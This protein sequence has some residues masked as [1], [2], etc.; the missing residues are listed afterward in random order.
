MTVLV[1]AGLVL[2]MA[3]GPV[4]PSPSETKTADTAEIDGTIN[5]SEEAVAFARNVDEVK[6]H[7]RASIRLAGDGQPEEAQFHAT[8][9]YTDYW[10]E[11]RGGRSVPRSRPPTNRSQRSSKPN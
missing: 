5:S 3:G 9:A 7:L 6:G 2:A 4:S 11:A 8:H 10:K 1:L